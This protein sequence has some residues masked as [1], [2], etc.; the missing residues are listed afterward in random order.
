MGIQSGIRVQGGGLSKHNP[1][2]DH[3]GRAQCQFGNGSRFS[4]MLSQWNSSPRA[5]R[6][7][8]VKNRI[9]P[10]ESHTKH[11]LRNQEFRLGERKETGARNVTMS[12]NGSQ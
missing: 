9:G 5:S 8:L 2:Y 4:E 12:F 6:V 11:A 1:K 10:S 3:Q 7:P